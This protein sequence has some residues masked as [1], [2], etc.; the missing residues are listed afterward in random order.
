MKKYLMLAAALALAAALSGCAFIES[1]ES[2]IGRSSESQSEHSESE[3]SSAEESSEPE[4]SEWPVTIEGVPIPEQP[5]SVAV[6]SPSL[7]EI[8]RDMGVASAVTGVGSY[9]EAAEGLPALGTALDPDI[10]AIIALA[11]Q[12]LLTSAAPPEQELTLLQQAGV[13]VVV[14]APANR[15]SGLK[16]LYTNLALFSSGLTE[17]AEISEKYWNDCMALLEKAAAKTKTLGEGKT[18]LYLRFAELTVATADTLEGELLTKLGFI[19]AAE[20]YGGWSYPEED[21]DE[22]S[23]DVVIADSAI[24]EDELEKS[25]LYSG[26]PAV[27]DG[28]VVRT[29]MEAFERQGI[30]MFEALLKA[31]TELCG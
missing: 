31:A 21:A 3:T 23:P 6:L 26:C 20:K 8:M 14:L 18:A 1:I 28:L 2:F 24:T 29:D 25:K 17:G 19:N 15:L 12:Y 22:L 5:Q 30:G 13:E 10:D 7:Y 4:D 9:C 27:K 16:T 11:P